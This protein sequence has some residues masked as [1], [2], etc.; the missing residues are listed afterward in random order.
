MKGRGENGK[1]RER[2]GVREGAAS[3]RKRS[4][5]RALELASQRFGAQYE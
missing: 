5:Y 3:T 1:G 4:S 2:A